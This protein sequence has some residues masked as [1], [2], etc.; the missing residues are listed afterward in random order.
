MLPIYSYRDPTPT[1]NLATDPQPGF[2]LNGD[3]DPVHDLFI[4]IIAPYLAQEL[5][6]KRKQEPAL[7]LKRILGSETGHHRKSSAS[8]WP[9]KVLGSDT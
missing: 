1:I 7:G 2:G 6:L 4:D 5:D 8:S 9:Q 3:P